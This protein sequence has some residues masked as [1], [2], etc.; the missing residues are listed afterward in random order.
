MLEL[1]VVDECAQSRA[2]Q[3]EHGQKVIGEVHAG[4]AVA[5]QQLDPIRARHAEAV[6]LV[7]VCRQLHESGHSR[8]PGELAVLHDPATRL[9]THQE[10]G[11]AHEL[12]GGEGGLVD[13][14][15]VGGEGRVRVR[16]RGSQGRGIRRSGLGDLDHSVSEDLS[17][18]RQHPHFVLAAESSGAFE[19]GV[20]GL[21]DQR[22]AS[23]A[24][25]DRAQPGE[26]ALG[27]G[28]EVAR[29]PDDA[30]LSRDVSQWFP[31]VPPIVRAG[32]DSGSL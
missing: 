32:P 30:R 2:A 5:E 26:L 8:A 3:A 31:F 28:L 27:R 7:D 12:V 11:E 22:G 15:G 29:T 16:D 18:F 24:C 10:V 25:V 23:E 6:E 20:F 14:V 9:I 17:I 21:F 1:A 13:D 19:R 4:R